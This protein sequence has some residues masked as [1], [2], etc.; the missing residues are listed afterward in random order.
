M[1]DDGFRAW[2]IEVN[3]D[4]WVA[5]VRS[6]PPSCPPDPPPWLGRGSTGGGSAVTMALL[7]IRWCP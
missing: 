4:P 2:L 3:S 7:L 1:L 5:E 6:L